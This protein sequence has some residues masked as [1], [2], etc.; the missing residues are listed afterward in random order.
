M[1]RLKEDSL[2]LCSL[3]LLF[4][5]SACSSKPINAI[6]HPSF[7]DNGCLT[8]TLSQQHFVSELPAKI[9]FYVEASGS[10]N[11]FF[12]SNKATQFKHDVWSV[13][14]DF[15][16]LLDEIY[17]FEQQKVQ[18]KAMGLQE[19]KQGMNG[20]AFS[21]SASTEVPEMFESVINSLNSEAGEVAVLVS[22]M[23]YSPVGSR[24]MDVKLSQYATD[25]R[26]IVKKNPH[27]SLSLVAATSDYL[28][29]SGAVACPESPYYYLI[30]GKAENVVWLKNG[31]A[32]IL[33]DDGRYV[34][35][36]D[37]GIDFKSPPF[38]LR[39]IDNG[40]QLGDEPT[41]TDIDMDYSDTCSFD[42]VVD[43][44]NYPWKLVDDNLLKDS[45][46]MKSFGGSSVK[47]DTIIYNIDNHYEKQLR[48]EAKAVVKLKV[49]DMFSD[50]DV[51]EWSFG[52]PETE[53]YGKFAS[54]LDAESENDLSKSF[55]ISSFIQGCFYGKS[56][57]WCKE[58]N[59]ILLSKTKQ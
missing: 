1:K 36:V 56:N 34:D 59:R 5:L 26:N 37:C 12:R 55:S 19:F 27:V 50:A 48:R 13:F 4:L 43:L 41:I 2:L 57:Y 11:G 16:A 10:M 21:S 6:Y 45:L 31:I 39:R 14:S 23:K 17:V 44:K 40:Y 30:I 38:V 49:F 24:T 42:I 28:D 47:I 33:Q 46:Y 29:K 51:I 22:D 20:G 52:I 53:I 8:D 9:K 25:V 7:D 32:T 35:A 3:S 58:P 15:E 54:F 18:P